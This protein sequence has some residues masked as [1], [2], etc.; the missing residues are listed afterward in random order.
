MTRK[1]VAWENIFVG[2]IEYIKNLGNLKYKEISNWIK[3]IG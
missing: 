1:F 2:Y 3:N